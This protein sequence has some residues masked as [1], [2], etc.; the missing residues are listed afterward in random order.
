MNL[1][2][3]NEITEFKKTTSEIKEG[4]I[5]I[6]AMLNKHCK[7]TLY[8]GVKNNG[9]I[10]GHCI[11]ENTLRFISQ[12]IFNHIKPQITPCI[13][14]IKKENISFIKVTVEGKNKPYSAYGRYYIRTSDEDRDISPH[15]LK[16]MMLQNINVDIIT[17]IESVNQNLTFFSIK[18]L[19]LSKGLTLDDNTFKNNMKFYNKDNKYNLL[20]NLLADNNDVSIKVAT[21]SGIDKTVLKKRNEY[22]YK[23][24]L[25]SM[26]QVL[27]YIE[28]INETLVEINGA[29]R[30]ETKL[31]DFLCFRE[32]WLNAC[33]HNSWYKYTPPAVYV[34]DDRIEIISTGGLPEDY[35]IEEFFCGIS[36]P[37][38]I[39]LQ[40]IMGQLNY[41]EQTG[42]G[43]PLIVSKYGK[44]AFMITDNFIVVTIPFNKII[45]KHLALTTKEKD[46][47]NCIEKNSKITIHE[48]SHL[49]NYSKTSVYKIIKHL[50]ELKIL[51]RE[52]SDKSGIW[53]V[54]HNNIK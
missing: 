30:T 16:Q 51:H 40:K 50:K 44:K 5:S 36:H 32:A 24:L 13:E 27:D 15:Q 33:L 17:K 48:L 28:A 7:A 14:V 41:V 37:L 42:H 10:I 38:N 53:I 34:F 1:G 49:V 23:C 22:G 26:Q 18:S 8:F 43:V 11:G 3:E 29:K 12:A 54:N 19:F 25:I 20:A 46:I 9:D 45:E 2:A 35:S 6:T 47:I 52:G 31:F 4:L 21:F 39:E